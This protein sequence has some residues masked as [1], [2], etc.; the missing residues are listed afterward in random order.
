MNHAQRA[1]IFIE[2]KERAKWHDK[3]LWHAR[4]ARDKAALEVPEWEHLRELASQIKE[5]VLSHLDEYLIEF[6][7]NA[8]ENGVVVHW[9]KDADEHNEIVYGLLERNGI[10][11]LVKSKSILTEECHLNQFL[12][13]QGIEVVDTDLGERI[14][15][16]RK[17]PPS[18]IVA[19]AIHIRKEEVGELFH[20]ELGTEKGESDPTRLTRAAR[21]DLRSHFLKSQ[22]AL[23][24][25]N[26]AV[27]ESGG[28]V[29]VTNEGNADMGVHLNKIQIHSVG[30]EKLIPRV[31]D[32]GVFTRLLARSATG[33]KLSVYTAHHQKPKVGGEMHVIL[34]DN[35]RSTHLGK[36][37]FYKGLACIRCGACMNTCPIYRRS[38]GYSYHALIPGPIG[39]ILNPGTDLK[40]FSDLPFASTLCGSCSDV[41]P[42]KIDIHSQLY[43]WRQLIVEAQS[44]FGAKRITMKLMGLVMASRRLFDIVNKALRVLLKGLPRWMIYNKF[45]KWGKGRELP[46]HEKQSFKDWYINN[47]LSDS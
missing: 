28:V 38:G 18:H 23:T 11:R 9:A 21:V 30:I 47:K 32:L 12:E 8:R 5:N 27:A 10:Q 46:T 29:V 33:Q 4:S 25:V 15:Q 16:L 43:K 20:R 36:K 37:E 26:F 19:P 35:G 22:A 41:C 31:K 7:K 39:S 17:E 6:E 2:D 13:Q 14:I 34:V 3:A 24:G 1:A 45:N 40:A 42:V 44:P